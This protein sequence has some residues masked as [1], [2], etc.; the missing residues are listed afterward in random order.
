MRKTFTLGA[1]VLFLAAL[2]FGDTFSGVL[3][4]AQCAGQQKAA[5]CNPTASTTAFA[6]QVSGGKTLKLD[7]DGNKKAADALKVSNNGADR[8]KDPN[9]PDSQVMATIEGTQNGDEVKVDS[10]VVK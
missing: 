5:A 2:A 9:S 1:G 6:I 10:I 3:V 8:A 7:A 4:D